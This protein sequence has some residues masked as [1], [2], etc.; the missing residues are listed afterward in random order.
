MAT[1]LTPDQTTAALRNEG[2]TF[3]EYRDWDTHNRNHR[4]PWGPVHG[5]MIHHTVTGPET[6][7]VALCYT[8]HSALPGP[9]CH[10]VGERDGR[11]YLVSNGRANHAGLGDGDVLAAV[12]NEAALPQD[13]E[14]DT[15][16][17][18]YFYGIELANRGDGKEPWPLRQYW[19]A[20]RYAAAICRAHGW[21]QRSVIGHKE[22]QPGK[23]D[24]TFD[25]GQFRADVA[26]QLRRPETRTPAPS[27]PT[28]GDDMQFTSLALTDAPETIA[29]GQSKVIYWDAEYQDGA[30]DHGAGGK[31]IVS[32]EHFTGMVALRFADELP[33]GVKV[34]MVHELDA[35]GTSDDFTAALAADL[36]EHTVPYTGRVAEDRNL[37]FEIENNSGSPIVLNWAAVRG[38]TWA[39]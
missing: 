24:P 36:A 33:T 2:V 8:G 7:A 27:T 1:P 11:V 3:L 16:G 13:N 14:T 4:G 25:M 6:D 17:N 39:L 18:R 23:I 37:V 10:A 29:A 31:T 21:S 28:A 15:D 9:L 26:T 35:G 19:A 32:G 34:R 22:W 38:G 20:V 30:G 12:K 5:V